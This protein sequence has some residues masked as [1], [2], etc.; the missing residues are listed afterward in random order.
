MGKHIAQTAVF[1]FQRPLRAVAFSLAIAAVLGPSREAAADHHTHGGEAGRDRACTASFDELP[2]GLSR[3]LAF[4]DETRKL[5][6]DH[7]VWTR[8]F[9]VSVAGDLP[10]TG[11]AA[12]R[13]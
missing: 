2:R 11:F 3:A 4:H 10:D 13:L 9:I 6:E 5:W 12:E 7:I 1:A 8:Q